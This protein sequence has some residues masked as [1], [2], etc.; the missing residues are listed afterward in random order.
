[1]FSNESSHHLNAPRI[2]HDV[3]RHSALTQ[4]RFL[5]EKRDVLT[6]HDTWDS[7]K[8]DCAGTHGARRQGRVQD[9]SS[10]HRGWKAPGVLESVHFPVEN[11]ASLLHAAVVAAA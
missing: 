2:L 9:G 7:I 11:R 8:Q 10:V 4:Q 6:N 1:M 5:A 3:D